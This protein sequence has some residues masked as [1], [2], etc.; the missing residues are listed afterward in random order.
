M[1][2]KNKNIVDYFP[3]YCTFGDDIEALED[4]FGNDAFVVWV[5][6]LQKLG[7][8]D[9]H[10]IDCRKSKQWLLYYSKL[11][12]EENKVIEILNELAE[13]ECIDKKLWSKK[14]IYSQNF[15]DNI[16]EAYKR[17]KTSPLTY[18]E[19]WRLLFDKKSSQNNSCVQNDIINAQSRVE[20]TRKDEIKENNPPLVSPQENN[21]LI[22]EEVFLKF[23]KSLSGVIENSKIPALSNALSVELGNKNYVQKC[24]NDWLLGVYNHGGKTKYPIKSLLSFARKNLKKYG[25]L[26]CYSLQ[27]QK[28]AETTKKENEKNLCHLMLLQELKQLTTYKKIFRPIKGDGLTGKKF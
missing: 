2:R 11:K 13:L 24:V 23:S 7:K 25:V 4:K 8:S 22:G 17:R 15:V 5:K 27:T 6:T 9:N 12:I 3:L 10:F 19:I 18:N 26:K 14:V 16:R 28:E 1:A 21:A 20:K